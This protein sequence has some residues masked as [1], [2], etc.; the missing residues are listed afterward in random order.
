MSVE[1]ERERLFTAVCGVTLGELCILRLIKRVSP[2]KKCEESVNRSILRSNI[3]LLKVFNNVSFVA[4]CLKCNSTACR[5]HGSYCISWFFS[6]KIIS[7]IFHLLSN[8]V[9][10]SIIF[11]QPVIP[12]NYPIWCHFVL[13]FTVKICIMLQKIFV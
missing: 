1:R 13:F 8:Y 6:H 2:L 9:I 7:S 10:I 5:F 11:S 3:V 4:M 12:E